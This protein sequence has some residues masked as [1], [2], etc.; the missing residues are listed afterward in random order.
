MQPQLL[1]R[2]NALA[3]GG[4]HNVDVLS[5][6]GLLQFILQQCASCFLSLLS[7]P[8][9]AAEAYVI[10]VV[11]RPVDTAIVAQQQPPPSPRFGS[12]RQVYRW[13]PALCWRC[14]FHAVDLLIAG[15]LVA[16]GTLRVS[17]FASHATCLVSSSNTQTS[18]SG[19]DPEPDLTSHVLL[20]LSLPFSILTAGQVGLLQS[21]VK[22]GRS[23]SFLE[24]DLR[25]LR[26]RACKSSHSAIAAGRRLRATLSSSGS[27]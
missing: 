23:P 14:R 25:G 1:A 11:D 8:G 4:K 16:F 5:G 17:L 27:A 10:L 20:C 19:R 9:L 12:A 21:M 6:S 26:T 24:F 22:F 3:A 15:A 18:T 13:I 7:Q 2:V